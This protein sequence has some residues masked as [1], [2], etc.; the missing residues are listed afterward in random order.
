MKSATEKHALP[1]LGATPR[2][3]TYWIGAFALAMTGAFVPKPEFRYGFLMIDTVIHLLLFA[4]L[5][6]IPMIWFRSRKTTFLLAFSMAP[7]GYLLENL[8]TMVTAE[9][10]NAR[11][12][13]GV[14]VN[15]GLSSGRAHRQNCAVVD[16]PT[17]QYCDQKES[18]QTQFKATGS[19]PL[20]WWGI[21]VAGT[22]LNIPA[23]FLPFIC[24]AA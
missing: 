6:F 18:L 13:G 14:N 17:V 12:R 4:V 8:H 7:L 1:E 21:Q 10:F 23:N 15:G 22:F 24:R 9:S 20:P 19:Y 16:T 3:K 2:L 5:A 11:I